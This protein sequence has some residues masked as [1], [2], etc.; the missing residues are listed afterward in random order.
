M[1]PVRRVALTG[2]NDGTACLIF[3]DAENIDIDI[4]DEPEDIGEPQ[5]DLI[6]DPN[7]ND[8][9]DEDANKANPKTVEPYTKPGTTKNP[10]LNPPK[11][12][13]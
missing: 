1:D 4:A 10:S 13:K 8:D 5:D 3:L 12:P 7:A 11:L 9:D 6:P 2:S